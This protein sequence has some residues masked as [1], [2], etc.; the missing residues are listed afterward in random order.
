MYFMPFDQ[1]ISILKESQMDYLHY[2]Y[3]RDRSK[4]TLD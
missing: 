1:L 4:T 2:C 3:L